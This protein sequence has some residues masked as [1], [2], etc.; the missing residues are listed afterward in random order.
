MDVL[1]GYMQR[2][3]HRATWLIAGL[4]AAVVPAIWMWGFAVDDALISVR[5]ARHIAAGAGW[6]FNVGAGAPSTDGVTPLPWPVFLLPLAHGSAL[7][8]LARAKVLGLAAWAGA[9]AWLGVNVGRA[10]ASPVWARA[11]ALATVALSV[12][13]AAHAVSGMETAFATS[14]ATCAALAGPRVRLAGVLAGLAASLRPELAP[15]AL[16]L[17]VG[18]GWAAR[19]PTSRVVG[20]ACLALGPFVLC[21]VVRWAVWGRPAPL[22]LLAKPSDVTHGFLYAGAG[23]VVALT[24]L[25]VL[26]PLALRRDRVAL[27][28]ALAFV[29]HVAAVVVVGGDWVPFFR[30]LAPVCPSLAWAA[31][32]ASAHAH[33]VATAVRSILAVGTGLALLPRAQPWRGLQADRAALVSSASA[34]LDDAHAVAALDV[35]WVGA[36]TEADIVDLAGLTDPEIAA[37]P[38]GHTSK[39][40]GAMLLLSRQTDAI[41]LYTPAG[42]P[43]GDLDAWRDA[44]WG[45]VVEARLA[46]DDV[47]Q[48]HFTAVAWLPLGAGPSGYVLLR[49]N[50]RD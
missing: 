1:F 2:I 5:Y 50:G 32:L 3:G 26:A 20:G 31:V 25:L 6:R 40:V 37:L 30:L 34:W 43:D 8:V 42:L 22:A 12:P 45:R 13:L 24:P 36:A 18:L 49:A 11:F 29:A 7:A 48:R 4:L 33:S 41:L 10:G 38:G 23:C 35:G 19:A 9:G 17:A 16:V 44:T 14:L 21:A 27:V 39:R 28:L 15:W 47:V 46:G